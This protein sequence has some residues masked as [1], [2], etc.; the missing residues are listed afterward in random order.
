VTPE[1]LQTL[2]HLQS[3]SFF[4]IFFSIG[5]IWTM[6]GIMAWPLALALKKLAGIDRIWG[7]KLNFLDC[8]IKGHMVCF[9]AIQAFQCPEFCDRMNTKINQQKREGRRD[10]HD[11]N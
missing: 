1:H 7:H 5:I 2:N 3:M 11:D 4:E 8:C 9:Y 6:G 10:G